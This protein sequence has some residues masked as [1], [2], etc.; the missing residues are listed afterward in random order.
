M[1]LEASSHV[2]AAVV[3]LP[4]VVAA[5]LVGSGLLLGFV[6]LP[7]LPATAW[8]AVGLATTGVTFAL[9]VLGVAL[10]FDPEALGM[11]QIE[12]FGWPEALGAQLRLGVDGIGLCFLLSTT[13]LVPLA[14]LSSRSEVRG[15]VRSWV[16]TCLFLETSLLGT[17]VS[18][19]FF[20]LLAR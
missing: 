15:S 6:G 2:L 3:L 19:H 10:G 1:N 11:Q 5:A 20:S 17:L 18:I 7:A 9:A 14:M 8:R 13:A 12:S 4:A 16:A